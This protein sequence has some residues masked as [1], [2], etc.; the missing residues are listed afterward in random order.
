MIGQRGWKDNKSLPETYSQIEA[1]FVHAYHG[2]VRF[3][4]HLDYNAEA[5]SN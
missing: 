4:Q 3:A 1:W 2:F 5:A